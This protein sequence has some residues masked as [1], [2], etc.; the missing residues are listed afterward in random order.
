MTKIIILNDRLLNLAYC[1]DEEDLRIISR[2]NTLRVS[3]QLD[4]DATNEE[5]NKIDYSLLYCSFLYPLQ[6]LKLYA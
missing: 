1:E 6:K 4:E 2:G 5:E 3:D